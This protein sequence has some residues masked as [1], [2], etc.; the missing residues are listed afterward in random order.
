MSKTEEK[1]QRVPWQ[2]IIPLI[3]VLSFVSTVEAGFLSGIF[4]VGMS[5]GAYS[6]Y[7]FQAGATLV[8]L[9]FILIGRIPGL[10][11]RVNPVLLAYIFSASMVTITYSCFGWPWNSVSGMA[12]LLKLAEP[13]AYG[14]YVP[15][16]WTPEASTWENLIAGPTVPLNW[17]EWAPS[18]VGWVV[19]PIVLFFFVLSW[20]NLFHHR[21][22]AVEELPVPYAQGPYEIVRNIHQPRGMSRT[23]LTVGL[24]LGF[25]FY[26]PYVFS[27]MFKW[28]P[29]IYGWTMDP[30]WCVWA[31]GSLEFTEAMPA[32]ARMVPGVVCLNLNPIWVALLYFAPISILFSWWFLWLVIVVIGIQVAYT[33][34]YYTGTMSGVGEGSAFWGRGSVI[35]E[36]A[37][38][39]LGAFSNFGVLPG[40]VIFYLILNRHYIASTLKAA[41]GKA[42][43]SESEAQLPISYRTN[44]MMMIVST[45]LLLIVLGIL[46]VGVISPLLI[47]IFWIEFLGW[48]R[49]YV[50]LGPLPLFNLTGNGWFKV[51]WPT[52]TDEMKTTEFVMSTAFANNISGWD[53]NNGFYNAVSDTWAGYGFGRYAEANPKNIFLVMVAA[54]IL[55]PFIGYTTMIWL[56]SQVGYNA[57]PFPHDW[58]WFSI[59]STEGYV[60]GIFTGGPGAWVPQAMLGFIVTGIFTFLRM[61]FAWWPLDPIGLLM[62]TNIEQFGFSGLIMP[63]LIAWILKVL[64]IR[65][66]G[67]KAY[68]QYGKPVAAG[69][70]GG[71]AVSIVLLGGPLAIYRFFYPG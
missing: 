20:T 14:K 1:R 22:L 59:S 8:L 62:A 57:L 31:A 35:Y 45:V 9:L 33:F 4:A 58:N 60:A 54:G 56:S 55:A 71:Y 11:E 29:D 23:L 37:P 3:V 15:V 49:V 48:M 61:R 12:P 50:S 19:L 66:G 63:P 42:G 24:V 26:V 16:F 46:G 65:V 32:M 41:F 18:Y 7:N 28:F 51:V 5:F 67:A 30:P 10:R 17:A 70:I 53:G 36:E 34:G 43:S 38:M 40:I 21:W 27:N 2:L 13:E 39:K 52:M 44:Y 47:F 69:F 68:D 64:T 6:S 25:L